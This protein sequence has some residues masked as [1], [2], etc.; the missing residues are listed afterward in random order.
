MTMY[1]K[2]ELNDSTELFLL[3]LYF[4]LVNVRMWYMY[5]NW[6]ITTS[7]YNQQISNKYLT[8][9]LFVPPN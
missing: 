2:D 7:D 5:N 3:T 1:K 6:T 9:V 4:G 8:K